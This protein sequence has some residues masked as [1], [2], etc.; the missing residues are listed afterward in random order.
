MTLVN[1]AKRELE[2]LGN[3]KDFDDCII[4]TVEAF[5]EYGH[6]GGS[7]EYGIAV[8]YD[9]LR[10]KNVSP[11]TDDP[12]EWNMVSSDTWQSMRCSEA[13]SLDGGKT[14]YL[15][16]EVEDTSDPYPLYVSR[17]KKTPETDDEKEPDV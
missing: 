11:L 7:A 3:D 6:S 12:K 13:F 17:V 10:Y 15:V 4:K 9:I 1:H 8:L 14:Y 5:L 2:L 16:S